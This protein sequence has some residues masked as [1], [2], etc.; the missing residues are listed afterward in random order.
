M[1]SD[2]ITRPINIILI[3]VLEKILCYTYYSSLLP[4]YK[5]FHTVEGF[6]SP[7]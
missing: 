2:I 6:I 1:T 3:F 7:K 4:Q 5:C